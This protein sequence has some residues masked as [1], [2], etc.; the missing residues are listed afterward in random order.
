MKTPLTSI[1]LALLLAGCVH[2]TPNWDRQ[3][4]SSVRAATAAQVADPSAQANPDPVTGI[5]GRAAKASQQ[6]YEKSFATPQ[7]HRSSMISGSA[8]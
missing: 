7:E 1:A 5:D 3:F 8:K 4:G 6:H 2:T